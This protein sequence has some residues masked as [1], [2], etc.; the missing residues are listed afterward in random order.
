MP[1]FFFFFFSFEEKHLHHLNVRKEVADSTTTTT[2]VW[3]RSKFLA[4]YIWLKLNGV[5]DIMA[6]LP[7]S[8]V[9]TE[10]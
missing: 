8:S 1:V 2:S 4:D 7:A 9:P 5:G 10:H 6:S 3:Y